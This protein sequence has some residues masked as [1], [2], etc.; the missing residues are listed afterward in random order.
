M[1]D[2]KKNMKNKEKVHIVGNVPSYSDAVP[3]SLEVTTTIRFITISLIAPKKNHLWFIECLK[4]IEEPEKIVIYDIFGPADNEYLQRIEVAIEKLPENIQVNI[5]PAIIPANV[6]DVL[7]EY[8]YFVLPTYGE[9][10]G[11]AIF[12]AFNAG[13]PVLISDKTPW[14]NLKEKHAGWDLILDKDL[15]DDALKQCLEVDQSD[16]DLL[17]IGARKVAEE[18][19]DSKDLKAQ[20]LEMFERSLRHAT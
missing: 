12:E 17:S 2:I 5:K 3:C 10:F 19:M 11:H 14:R 6:Q 1:F 18:Y 7:S 15:W 20:Y 16:Y 13:L 4:R 8:H 9:N